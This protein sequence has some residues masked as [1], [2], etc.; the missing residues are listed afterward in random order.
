MKRR[1]F[2]KKDIPLLIVM[3][4]FLLLALLPHIKMWLRSVQKEEIDP[5]SEAE[6]TLH[7]VFLSVGQGDSTLVKLGNWS[8]L[9]DTGV[10]DSYDAVSSGLK[11][12]GVEELDAVFITHPHYDHSGCLQ[13]ILRDYP[14][15]H[16]YFA[17][18]PE[19]LMPTGEWYER[20]LD[21]IG[22]KHIPLS[23]LYRG[24]IVNAGDSGASFETLWSGNGEDLNNCSLVLRL[25]YG[26]VHALFTGDAEWQ[27][28]KEL[29]DSGDE[30][31]SQILKVG[32]HGSYY[33]SSNQFIRKVQPDYAIIS[34][35]AENEFGYPKD[36]VINR[37]QSVG[38]QIFRT[39]LQGNIHFVIFNDTI[40]YETEEITS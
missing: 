11:E 31:S 23:I 15:G 22:E 28:E 13:S 18:I 39:D 5:L 24:D 40:R 2:R 25:S 10:Y 6:R 29:L 9:I 14:V 26:K 16:V 1:R 35:G 7:V 33:S 30:L 37:F 20:V 4:L 27:T 36:D 12:Y 3:S 19:E 21:I 32:H 38:A 8:A 34:C 17:D